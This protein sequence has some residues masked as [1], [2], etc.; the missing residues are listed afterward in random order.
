MRDKCL[1]NGNAHSKQKSPRLQSIQPN[2][3]AQSEGT[4]LISCII[5]LSLFAVYGFVLTSVVYERSLKVN[6]EVDRLKAYYLAE[7]AILK[8][9]AEIKSLDDT[10]RDGLGNVPRT[11]LGDGEYYASH[12]PAVLTI[13]GT[14]EVNQIKRIVKIQYEGL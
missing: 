1:P 4:I 9:V 11:K 6:L 12:D 8:S 13:V 2:P 7:A 14:G 3:P 10:D 5:I